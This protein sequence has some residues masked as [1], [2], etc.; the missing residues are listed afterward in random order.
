M[1]NS[2]ATTI[3]TTNNNGEGTTIVHPNYLPSKTLAVYREIHKGK[4]FPD[5]FQ[6][7]V[8]R[9]MGALIEV[10]VDELRV[11]LELTEHKFEQEPV[12]ATAV[13]KIVQSIL[14][15]ECLYQPVTLTQC[16]GEMY[17]TGGRNR[18]AAILYIN[19]IVLGNDTELSLVECVLQFVEHESVL[20]KLVETDNASR[21]MRASEKGITARL[22]SGIEAGASLAEATSVIFNMEVSKTE[23]ITLLTSLVVSMNRKEHNRFNPQTVHVVA[24]HFVQALLTKTVVEDTVAEWLG[25]FWNYLVNHY[26]A[27]SAAVDGKVA[28]NYAEVSMKIMGGLYFDE[29]FAPATAPEA[30]VAPAPEAPVAT[31]DAPEAQAD[32][33]PAKKKGKRPLRTA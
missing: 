13:S 14:K 24:K 26:G 10:T 1:T 23:R 21:T 11:A 5:T 20:Y 32:A 12:S 27:L 19:D 33:P 4:C 16:D 15:D 31:T 30:P 18:T 8:K 9:D 29:Y 3:A 2:K 22:Q 17:I 7:T 25:M 6:R 28:R